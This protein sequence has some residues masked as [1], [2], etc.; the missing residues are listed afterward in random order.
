MRHGCIGATVEQEGGGIMFNSARSRGR[1][2]VGLLCASLLVAPLVA[3][4]AGG[5]LDPTF[6]SGGRVLTSRFYGTDDLALQADGKLV[7]AGY[8]FT[9]TFEFSIARFTRSG[10]F[11]RS[12]S[13]DGIAQ[14]IFTG[15]PARVA[16]IQPDGR[17]VAIG[18]SRGSPIAIARLR[19]DGR[20]DPTFGDGG[21]VRTSNGPSGCELNP[22]IAGALTPHGKIVVATSGCE[23]RRFLVARYRHDGRLDRTFGDDGWTSVSVNLGVYSGE[24]AVVVQ[25]DGMIV[26]AGSVVYDRPPE[27]DAYTEVALARFRGGGTL[28]PAFGVGGVALPSY[29]SELCAMDGSVQALRL[30]PDGKLVVG[31][32]AGCS[33]TPGGASHGVIGLMRLRPD[34]SLDPRFGDEGRVITQGPIMMGLLGLAIA[35]DGRIVVTGSDPHWMVRRYL[36]GGAVDRTFGG[37]GKVETFRGNGY[38]GDVVVQRDGRIVAGGSAARHTLALA[39]YRP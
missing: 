23:D 31:G 3:R 8:T 37:D 12:F 10:R 21:R 7:V 36:P 2:F 33:A 4:A 35:P 26:V 20:L 30:Q 29:E 38:P 39:R 5:A 27:G 24:I 6:G 18:S 34:G 15:D 19:Q 32:F 9:D 17:I 14:R 1:G 22:A 28:D 13:D 11:D 25:R 16:L